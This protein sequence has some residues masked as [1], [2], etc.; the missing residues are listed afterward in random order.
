MMYVA[1][2]VRAI[3]GGKASYIELAGYGAVADFDADAVA[4]RVLSRIV[5]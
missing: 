1:E 4:D 3:I 5:D 2:H